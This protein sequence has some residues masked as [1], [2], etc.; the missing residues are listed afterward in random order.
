M[1]FVSFIH[2]NPGAFLIYKYMNW[3]FASRKYPWFGP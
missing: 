2:V 1:Q 3:S